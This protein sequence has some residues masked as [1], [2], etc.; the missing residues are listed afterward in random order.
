[1]NG[2]AWLMFLI[3]A[4]VLWGGLAYSLILSFKAQNGN[5]SKESKSEASKS[6]S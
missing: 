2:S 1:M 5:G 6:D 3:G 4:V